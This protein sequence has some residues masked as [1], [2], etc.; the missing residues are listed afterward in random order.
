M[1][2]SITRRCYLYCPFTQSMISYPTKPSCPV[3]CLCAS[4]RQFFSSFSLR[5]N[6]G[7][8]WN[9]FQSTASWF[10][11]STMSTHFAS[12]QREPLYANNLNSFDE[13]LLEPWPVGSQC[14]LWYPSSHF[15]FPAANE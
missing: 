2:N 12:S 15:T 6:A 10:E 5:K 3:P 14:V 8:F 13:G 4:V 7:D 1:V 9:F 11:H